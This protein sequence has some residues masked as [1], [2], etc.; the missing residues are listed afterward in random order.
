MSGW[1][2]V[3]L[4]IVPMLLAGCQQ[5]YLR[6]YAAGLNHQEEFY[7]Q[8]RRIDSLECHSELID[9]MAK[10]KICE[11]TLEIYKAARK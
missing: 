2:L 1:P 10:N 3:A 7:S 8:V 4:V 6:G 9:Q 5:E 11:G